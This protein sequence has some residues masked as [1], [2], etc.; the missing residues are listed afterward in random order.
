MSEAQASPPKVQPALFHPRHWGSWAAMG[1]L[2]VIGLLPYPQILA[3]GRPLGRLAMGLLKRRRA[4][5]EINLKLCFPELDEA[6]RQRLLTRHFE[7]LGISLFEIS[8]SWWASDAKLAPLCHLHGIEHL[9]QGQQRGKGVI[10]LTAHFLPI[11]IG[12]RLL[13]MHTDFCAMYRRNKNP[14]IEWVMAGSRERHIK[15]AIPSKA[16]KSAIRALRRNEILWYAPD[17]NTSPKEAVFANFFGIPASTN[18]AT[19]RLA[20]ISGATVIPYRAIRRQDGKGYD[21]IFE[22]PLGGFPSDDLT[23]DTQRINDLIEG[24]ARRDPEQYLWVHRR[25]RHRP[26]AD[27]PPLYPAKGG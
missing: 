27:A 24:W 8:L 5:A 10:L 11:D 21:L 26:D 1:L 14:V 19:A 20:R 17:Q 7:A 18:S 3:L 9:H 23:A 16:V 2:R 22:A 6:A 12:G 4:I 25:F 13:R 15:Q